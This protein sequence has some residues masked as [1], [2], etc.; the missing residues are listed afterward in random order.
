MRVMLLAA[1]IGSRLR[2]L[3][4]KT[5]KCLVKIKGRPLLDIWLENLTQNGFGPFLI[6]THYLAD[7]VES[8]VDKSPYREKIRLIN[9]PILLGTAGTLIANL[10]FFNKQDGLLVHADNYCLADFLAFKKAHFNRPSECLMTMMTFRTSEPELCGVVE[11]NHKNVLIG[12][13]EKVKNPKGNLANGAIYILSP[14]LL[15]EL[16]ENLNT[17]T[18][19]STEVIHKFLGRIYTYET[20]RTLVDI[21]TNKAYERVNEG[22]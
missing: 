13:E 20:S 16:E 19:F 10:D 17:A 1:G 2:P 15:N 11:I 7:Q 9:E 5:P 21:G 14:K 6:N 8:F 22:N 18:N 3:T 4:N 12:F